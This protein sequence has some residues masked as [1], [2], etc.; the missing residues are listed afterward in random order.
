MSKDMKS[1]CLPAFTGGSLIIENLELTIGIYL[2][3]SLVIFILLVISHTL[4]LFLDYLP[5]CHYVADCRGFQ[6]IMQRS[7]SVI[8]SVFGFGIFIAYFYSNNINLITFCLMNIKEPI[9]VRN[10]GG[11]IPTTLGWVH[12]I[13][14]AQ[15]ST[16]P[17]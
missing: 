11:K 13:C 5:T 7:S 15:I 12:R 8:F 6:K 10:W 2:S 1:I 16:R 9:C 17:P 4:E 14:S 3:A